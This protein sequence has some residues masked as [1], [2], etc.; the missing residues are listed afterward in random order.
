[1]NSIPDNDQELYLLLENIKSGMLFLCENLEDGKTMI[2]FAEELT[3]FKN[4]YTEDGLCLVDGNQSSVLNA[5]AT[6]RAN[7]FT[8]EES[9]FDF[10]GALDYEL[11][12]FEMSIGRFN[13]ID[14]V[15][16]SDP[17]KEDKVH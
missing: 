16:D 5:I 2:N 12:D 15:D 6:A 7:K 14:I 17:L 9:K 10:T 4:W 3:K 1:M 8:G 11:S 13:G